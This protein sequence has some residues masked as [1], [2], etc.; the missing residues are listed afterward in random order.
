MRSRL[1]FTPP[2][3]RKPLR[4]GPPVLGL[5]ALAATA[6]FLRTAYAYVLEG[7]KWPNGSTVVMQLSLGNAG[8]TLS[9]GNTNW[10]SAAAPALDMWNQVIGG[11]RFGKVM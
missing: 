11:M 4:L 1:S 8:H 6:L 5:F 9:D 3:C 10:N 7:P 2:F